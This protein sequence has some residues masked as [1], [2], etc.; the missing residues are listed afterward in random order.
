VSGGA[1]KLLNISDT[2]LA[3]LTTNKDANWILSKLADMNQ[4]NPALPSVTQ[5]LMRVMGTMNIPV[6]LKNADGTTS[7]VGSKLPILIIEFQ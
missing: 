3:K 7:Q 4:T 6:T 1:K 5:K 2:A